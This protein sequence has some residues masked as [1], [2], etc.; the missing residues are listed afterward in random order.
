MS[1][2]SWLV[3]NK[4][5]VAVAKDLATAAAIFVGGLWAFRKF[6]IKRE[7]ASQVEFIVDVEFIGC[8]SEYLIVNLIAKLNNKAG[9]RLSISKF[10]FS[11]LGLYEGDQLLNGGE[12]ISFQTRFP[13]RLKEGGTWLPPRW[14]RTFVEPNTSTRYSHIAHVPRD[15]LQFVLLHGEFFY[16]VGLFFKFRMRHTANCIKAVPSPARGGVAP[17]E[18][19]PQ[20]S[21]AAEAEPASRELQSG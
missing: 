12:E 7:F 16:R 8:H 14:G 20:A 15:K 19:A 21:I 13:H 17:I 2:A 3:A 11:L 1:F 6:G 5:E 18:T 9:P 4:E 10:P